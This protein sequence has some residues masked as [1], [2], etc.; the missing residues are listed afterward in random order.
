MTTIQIPLS[1]RKYPGLIA[2]IDEED[3]SLVVGYAWNVAICDGI[4]Y[5]RAY[6]RGSGAKNGKHVYMHRLIMDAQPGKPV[7][8]I[9]SS[10]DNRRANLRMATT[11]QNGANRGPT[12]RNTSGYKGVTWSK[13][14]SV[15]RA[16][17]GANQ[18]TENLG[19]FDTPEDAARAYDLAA[20]RYFG[21]FARTNFPADT[22]SEATEV[23]ARH[24]APISRSGGSNSGYRGVHRVPRKTP[25]VASIMANGK[26]HHLGRFAT[27]EEA[28]R[29]Y[30]RMARALHG[31]YAIL[32]FPS[33]DSE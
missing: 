3:L 33:L 21:E 12:R 25:Y 23:R 16:I 26:N 22:Y 4:P 32:N 13:K 7:D 20:L 19:S 2:L 6:V 1:S 5:A 14:D 28:A 30:D 10:L 17:I 24:R 27:A 18:E 11:S 15:W 29:A 9:K 31:A 8:H